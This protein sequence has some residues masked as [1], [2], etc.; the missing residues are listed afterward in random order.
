MSLYKNY[1]K[2]HNEILTH[3]WIESEKHNKD[4]GFE[5]ALTDWLNKHRECWARKTL[6]KEVDNS[7]DTD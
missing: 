4:V 6:N 3:K 1:K 5:F 7:T 2:L